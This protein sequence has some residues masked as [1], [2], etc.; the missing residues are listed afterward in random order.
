[1]SK[2]NKETI[3]LSKI[4]TKEISDIIEQHGDDSSV[5]KCGHCELLIERLK[6]LIP[7]VD[8]YSKDTM[9]DL[10]SFDD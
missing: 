1:M 5:F 6:H 10:P 9:D 3:A 2:K 4:V 8:D 7:I